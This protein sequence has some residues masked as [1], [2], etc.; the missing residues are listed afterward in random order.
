MS[1]KPPVRYS[2]DLEEVQPD[3]AEVVEKLNRDF[4]KIMRTTAEDYGHAVRSVHAKGHAILKGEVTIPADL[5]PELA[6]GLF[7]TPGSYPV[8]LRVST[9]AGDILT[10]KI[11]L[12]RGLAMKV[13][14]VEG[15]RLPDAE[16][17]TQ[18]FIFNNGT[19]FVAKT[20]KQF[21][22]NVK[23]L[24]ATTDVAEGGKSVF[25]KVLRGVNT[26]LEAVGIESPTVVTMGGEPNSHPL[27]QT[28]NGLTPYR[29][30]DYVAK[31]RVVPAA[32][33]MRQLEN[34]TIDA[35]EDDDAIR[36]TMQADM[37]GIDAEWD[38]QVQL[39][40]DTEKQPVEDPGVEW[41]EEVS[42][43]ITVATVRAAAQDSWD[44]AMV[45]KVNE[46]TRFSIWTGLEAHR[47]M[48]NINRARRETYRK[49]AEFRAGFNRCPIHEP[50]AAE[51][52]A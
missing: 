2:T 39:L 22:G 36:H 43:W 23:M 40:R 13:L 8:L 44:D 41:P 27:G 10:D 6:Q 21:E 20:A 15:E 34:A 25:S 50:A 28:Y 19:V 18:D 48:G 38:F 3:E 9:N 31:Y 16:G 42:P 47:P 29:W 35:S 1:L 11:S 14:G 46:E 32:A 7:A 49:S 5:A 4:D 26:A 52:T 30:G 33:L 37:R 24:A 17:D 12:P 45:R 51:V